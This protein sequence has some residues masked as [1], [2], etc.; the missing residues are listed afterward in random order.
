VSAKTGE[1]VDRVLTDFIVSLAAQK[2][3]IG[4]LKDGYLSLLLALND[5][6]D[7]DLLLDAM[8]L[9]VDI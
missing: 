1:K 4:L 6:F 5:D 9:L 8:G 7:E 2:R 3:T